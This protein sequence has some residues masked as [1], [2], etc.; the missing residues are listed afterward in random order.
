MKMLTNRIFAFMLALA[1]VVLPTASYAVDEGVLPVSVEASARSGTINGSAVTWGYA[2]GQ[3]TISGSGGCSS[4]SSAADQP[5]AHLRG[6]ITTVWFSETAAVTDIS[7][8]FDGCT[9]LE[10][11]LVPQ[12]VTHI[13]TRAFADCPRLSA[14]HIQHREVV[15]TVA[16]DAFALAE[17]T[18][19]TLQIL[20]Y[21]GYPEV[22]L[23]F[24]LY[25]WA[26]SNRSGLYFG[27]PYGASLISTG[28]HIGTCASCGE[29]SFEG[30]YTTESH[31]H[32][33]YNQ[34]YL[35]GYTEYTGSYST[36]NHGDG[37]YGSWSCPDCGSHSYSQTG[38]SAPSCTSNGYTSYSCACGSSYTETEYATGHGSI[39]TSWSGC[40][41]YDYCGRCGQLVNSGTSHSS[42]S[43]GSWEYYNRS[44]HRRYYSCTS[45]GDGS[46]DYGYHSTSTKYSQ[47]TASQHQKGS[48]C[49]TCGSYVGSVSNEN[50]SFS[51]GSWTNYSTT[52]HRR[53]ATCSL[54]GYSTYEYAN[55][56]LTYGNWMEHSDTQHKRTASC[57]CGYSTTEYGDH[58]DNNG[59]GA[60][61]SCGYL[62]ARFSV[63]VPATLSMTMSQSG[64][65]FAATSAQ[66]VNNSTGAVKVTSIGLTAENGWALVPY[67]SSMA[68]AKVD[69]RLIGFR[70]N[71][72]RSS[73]AEN[74]SLTGNWQIAKGAALAL[75]YDA[76]VSATTA[77]IDEQVLTVVFV[78]EWA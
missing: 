78:L 39:S 32:A 28:Y 70:L 3:L 59:D 64:E 54:C 63:T 35:C 2:D 73:G 33:D 71:D 61:D 40:Y 31:P 16:A 24:H 37:S 21:T 68:D 27:D 53:T 43:Y 5:W 9:A 7:H 72:A 76:V 50:H 1:L 17:T 51:Y 66:I 67:A 19:V 74:L 75:D 41:W 34:C 22:V 55:H 23:P 57:T 4:F 77:V 6:E 62:M 48:Y 14:L 10:T 29:N 45:C 20:T 49:A 69:S 13:G 47:Y 18:G 42:Y 58:A 46:Y 44:Q 36:K 60:C 56:S 8:W 65:V 30:G 52:Q 11:V 38:Y 26:A 25:D 12:S 15:P